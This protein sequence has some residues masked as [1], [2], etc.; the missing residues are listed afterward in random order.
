E[1]GSWAQPHTVRQGHR[2]GDLPPQAQ[3]SAR[4]ERDTTTERRK[5]GLKSLPDAV[6]FAPHFPP[7]APVFGRL[8][9]RVAE[10]RKEC[11]PSTA[12]PSVGAQL[13][14]EASHC[15]VGRLDLGEGPQTRGCQHVVRRLV[16]GRRTQ[17][18]EEPIAE[19]RGVMVVPAER[20]TRNAHIKLLSQSIAAC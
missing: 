8:Q 13:H 14:V 17:L 6:Q 5:F 7:L 15:R 4:E 11:A 19:L 12:Q 10:T 2:Y 9:G 20:Y 3:F 18:L 1:I 16:E